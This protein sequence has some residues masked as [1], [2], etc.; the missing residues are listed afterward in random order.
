[1][2]LTEFVLQPR[3]PYLFDWYRHRTPILSPIGP[4]DIELHVD[5][6]QRRPP[7]TRMLDVVS[8][9]SD[10]FKRDVELIAEL[11]LNEYRRVS[12]D[13][14]WQ[15]TYP[16]QK[17]KTYRGLQRHLRSR[18]LSLSQD[19]IDDRVKYPGVV[20]ISPKW[21]IEHGIHYRRNKSGG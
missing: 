17:I 3:G 12:E 10:A 8:T 21:D 14:A 11:V 5:D 1:M 16:F 18:C 6:S 7:D 15:E 2:N 4:F 9:L 20:Y 13:I 19:E